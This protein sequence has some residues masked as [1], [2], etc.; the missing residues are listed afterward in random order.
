MN[1][2]VTL[3]LLCCLNF[4][5]LFAQN[6]AEKVNRKDSILQAAHPSYKKVSG[7]DRRLFGENYRKDWDMPVK[8]PILDLATWHGGL[9]PVKQ[10]SGMESK[11]LRLVDKS[12]QEW[13]DGGSCIAGPDGNWVVAPVSKQEQLIIATLEHTRVMEERQNF[14]PSGHY[15]RPNIV[16]LSVNRE[17]Q[18][19]VRFKDD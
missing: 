11:S 8:L 3:I 12:G 15:A 10:G 13:A 2:K 9:T 1:I 6:A 17:R 14:D 5:R 19:L 18:R 4:S 16:Q 7:V